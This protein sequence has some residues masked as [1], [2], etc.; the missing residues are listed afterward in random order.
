MRRF[1]QT[2][3]HWIAN[4]GERRSRTV[5][6]ANH[7]NNRGKRTIV[8]VYGIAKL[9]CKACIAKLGKEFRDE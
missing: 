8:F 4:P 1:P 7:G 3:T 5:C 6:G 2:Q 9:T